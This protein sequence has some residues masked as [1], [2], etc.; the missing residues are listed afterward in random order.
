MSLKTSTQKTSNTNKK[1][2][3]SHHRHS[4]AYLKAYWPYLPIGMIVGLGFLVNHI[5]KGSSNVSLTSYT[6]Y[7]LLESSI[8]L[9]ALAIFFLRHAFAWHKV[10]IKEEQFAV[11]HP[12]LDI[13]LVTIAV[14]GL[15]LSHHL[16]LA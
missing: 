1:I 4:K 13:M 12:Y 16:M 10:L 3:G 6:Y 2:S 8:A 11:K 7:D 5:W 9:F 14:V 15:L